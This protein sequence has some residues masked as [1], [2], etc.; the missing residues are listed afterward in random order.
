M[1]SGVPVALSPTIAIPRAITAPMA[2]CV[3]LLGMITSISTKM[4]TVRHRECEAT[5]T[6]SRRCFLAAIPLTPI[7]VGA[8]EPDRSAVGISNLQLRAPIK[9]E[10]PK[11][12][13]GDK[14]PEDCFRRQKPHA[15][16]KLHLRNAAVR[17]PFERSS[18]VSRWRPDWLA[19]AEGFEMSAT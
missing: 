8:R 13:L 11:T 2:N 18:H 3:V 5:H 15:E 6:Y 17:R 7:R 16:T 4:G 14:G 10:T 1:L 12:G 9:N 19:G